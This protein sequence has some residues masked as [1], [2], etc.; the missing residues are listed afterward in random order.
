M[1]Q[2]LGFSGTRPLLRQNLSF[3]KE[4]FHRNLHPGKTYPVKKEFN[5]VFLNQVFLYSPVFPRI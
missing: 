1:E 2:F 4:S 3:Q 5:N